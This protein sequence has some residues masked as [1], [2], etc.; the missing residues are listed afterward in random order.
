MT[1]NN[2]IIIKTLAKG[3][4]ICNTWIISGERPRLVYTVT[5]LWYLSLFV[6]FYFTNSLS[7]NYKST[8][9]Q[10]TYCW[11]PYLYK[12]VL[13]DLAL[14]HPP[15]SLGEGVMPWCIFT[16]GAAGFDYGWKNVTECRELSLLVGPWHCSCSR[17]HL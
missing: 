17:R 12:Q 3:V 5:F 9:T 6:I 10:H 15:S 13:S 4:T 7:S 11:H 2:S 1:K 14:L 16:A 8:H